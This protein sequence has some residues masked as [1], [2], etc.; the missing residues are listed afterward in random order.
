MED[1]ML[2]DI[3]QNLKEK[4]QVRENLIELKKQIKGNLER[5]EQFLSLLQYDFTM[6][7][8]FLNDEDP[9][10]RKNIAG[11]IGEMEL[12]GLLPELYEAYEEETTLFVKTAY[13]KAFQKMDCE[14]YL[15]NFR[16]RLEYLLSQKFTEEQEKHI[17]E[18]IRE[19]TLLIGQYETVEKHYFIG[20]D[21]PGRVV[22]TTNR[23]YSEL[24][25]NQLEECNGKKISGGVLVQYEDMRDFLSIRTYQEVLFPLPWAKNLEA[26]PQKIAHN[27]LLGGLLGFLDAKHLGG[28]HYRFRVEVRGHLTTEQ[29]RILMKKTATALE[30]KS[31][32]RLINS[33]SDYE[34]EIRLLEAQNGAFHAYLKL[35][36]IPDNRFSYR[37]NALASS[38]HP[39]TAATV[40]ELAKPYLKENA[41]VL[42]PFC[43]TGTMLIERNFAMPAHPLYGVDIYGKAIDAGRENASIAR[44]VINFVNRNFAEF[45]HEYLFDEIVTNMPIVTEKQSEKTIESLYELLLTKGCKHLKKGGIAVVYSSNPS[46]ASN[47]FRKHP[48]WKR[49]ETH[50]IYQREAS[51][52]YILQYIG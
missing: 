14:S 29:K 45:K 48:E 33:I 27:I 18:E 7:R 31:K 30:Q 4:K 38:I 25:L 50:Q 39:V 13:L 23:M 22:L 15:P 37:K 21:E 17:T 8:E 28:G 10:V 40:M 52:L 49:L 16:S 26:D 20:Y 11:I 2:N 41:Q 47:V 9:K 19:L 43:G 6:L 5:Q 35:Y 42:D 3:Y 1:F 44:T 12:D 46:I 32:H 34:I 36:T 24:T 51:Y